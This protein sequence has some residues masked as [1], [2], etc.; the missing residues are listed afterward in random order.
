MMMKMP[1]MTT[2]PQER[3]WDPDLFSQLLHPLESLCPTSPSGKALPSQLYKP[4]DRI[5]IWGVGPFSHR[6]IGMQD[7]S[8]DVYEQI[9]APDQRGISIQGAGQLSDRLDIIPIRF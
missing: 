4:E 2:D 3:K 7:V 8:D 1:R 9:T 6:C 5:Y